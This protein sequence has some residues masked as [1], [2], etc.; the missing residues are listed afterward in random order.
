V[1]GCQV[2]GNLAT[3]GAERERGGKIR[4][5]RGAVC[6]KLK[7]ERARIQYIHTVH[8]YNTIQ[9]GSIAVKNW[10]RRRMQYGNSTV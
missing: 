7:K 4:R 2:G 10:L 6:E 8:T 9:Y 3:K 5:E 1:G